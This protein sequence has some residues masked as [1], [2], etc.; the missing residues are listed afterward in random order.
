MFP[1]SLIKWHILKQIT[2]N[3]YVK[4]HKKKK[5]KKKK[6]K[7]AEHF[8]HLTESSRVL[9]KA[10]QLDNFNLNGISQHTFLM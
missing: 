1:S 9:K 4:R 7:T 2:T 5:K 10:S 3:V 6:K 8:C